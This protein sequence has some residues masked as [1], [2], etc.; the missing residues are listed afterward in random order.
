MFLFVIL[1]LIAFISPNADY[2]KTEFWFPEDLCD[3]G[4]K[5]DAPF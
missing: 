1:T 3:L 5:K 2:G 4:I